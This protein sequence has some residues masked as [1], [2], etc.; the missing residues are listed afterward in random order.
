VP[1]RQKFR[2]YYR[3]ATS[4]LFPKAKPKPEHVQAMAPLM[5][6]METGGRGMPQNDDEQADDAAIEYM[7][8]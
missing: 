3:E 6:A 1:Y 5:S 7:R 8:C 4:P 2:D